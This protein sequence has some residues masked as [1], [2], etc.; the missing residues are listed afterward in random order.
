[1][2]DSARPLSISIALCTYN[3]ARYL[4]E[5]LRS[6]ARQERPPDEVIACDD[7]SADASAAILADFAATS[8]FPVHVCRNPVTL[9]VPG[10]FTRAIELCSGDVIAPC[11]QD[12]RWLP[13]KLK[14]VE[15]ALAENPSAGLVF[16]DAEL[17]NENLKPLGVT[18][19]S[20]IG[21]HRSEQRQLAA[22]DG[23]QLFV[24]RNLVSGAT[25]AFRSQFRDLVLPVPHGW[26][27]D[28]WIALLVAALT[29]VFP[30]DEP[31]LLYR[32]HGAQQI[33]ERK[34]GVLRDYRA[35][36]AM[37]A[38]S[39]HAIAD[40]FAEALERLRGRANVPTERLCI[41]E[42]KVRHARVRGHMR[43]PGARRLPRILHE[44][45]T[46]NYARYSRGWKA[47]A[48]DLFL[49]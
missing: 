40:R 39:F 38:A 16:S 35:A 6:L 18:M 34:R 26:L 22:G 15:R 21:L 41:L 46:G 23:L 47:I 8:H 28:A 12:D 1:M 19:W 24:R 42:D 44:W 13:Q 32:Q 33:G 45:R 11:D 2:T 43:E 3:G 31:L 14:V 36:R 49:R 4:A 25:M 29:P 30:I 10:N 48:Q 27:H 7:N 20:T 17:V 9:G 37:D 5:Q